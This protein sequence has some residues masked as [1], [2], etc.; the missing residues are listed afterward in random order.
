VRSFL[1]GS[2][3]VRE[4]R[5]LARLRRARHSLHSLL[6]FLLL[7]LVSLP[8]SAQRAPKPDK[9]DKT[10][11]KTDKTDKTEKT[12]AGRLKKEADVLMDQDRYVDALALY[13]RA[14]ELTS[15]PAL[16]Y[17][18]GRALEAMGDYPEALDKLE[19]FDRDGS[20][21]L[22]AKV[23]GLHDLINDLR[24]RIATLV[25]TTNATGARLIIREKTAGTLQQKETRV[26]TR[27]GSAT[28]EVSAEGYITFKKEIELAAGSLVRV[29]AQLVLKKSD[30]LVIVRSR[31]SADIAIDGKAIGRSPLE[32]RLPAGQHTLVADAAGH[33]SEKV[34][35]TLAL[36]D[37]REL[38]IELRKPSSPFTKW[39]FW[40]IA[41]V[42]VAGGAATIVALSIEKKATPGT[43]GEGILPGP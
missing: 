12:E 4:L 24:G 2:R 18:Q 25:I 15:D 42:V 31:P 1:S 20:Q 13:A 23:P 6:V 7:A 22:R 29:D 3:S 27:A 17:N 5:S 19:R 39:W 16:L 21:A 41:G 26:R 34:A 37:K 14:Y 43:F 11:D 30:A 33:E 32:L 36:G 10:T 35:M 38:D 28:I 40:T 8:A 9:T